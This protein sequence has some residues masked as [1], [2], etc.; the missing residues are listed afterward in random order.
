[1]KNLTIIIGLITCVLFQSFGFYNS[2][3]VVKFLET[4]NSE[5]LE[6]VM[7][8]FEDNSR[9]S[10]HFLPNT[11][12]PREGISLKELN[13][14]QKDLFFK[15]LGYF[16]SETGYNKTKKI[17]SLESVLAELGGDPDYRNPEAY[18]IAIY[19]NPKKD[20]LWAW[21]FEGHHVALNFTVVNGIITAS[22]RFFGANPAIV[23]SGSRK[24]ERTL[25][26][27]EKLAYILVN[28]LT[29]KQREQAIIANVA[30]KDILTYNHSKVKPL[31]PE[32]ILASTLN[33]SQKTQLKAIIFE[34]LSALPDDLAH[35]R[36]AQIHK[37]E[38]NDL[39]FAWAGSTK[40]GEPH[41]YRIQG[42]T[43]LIEL[44]N[45]QT[46]ANHIHCVWR[47]FDGDFGRDLIMEH[48]KKS[49]HHN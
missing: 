20:N 14:E 44:D 39:R 18:F 29:E 42:K 5:Q 13:K 35:I 7:F 4:L 46:N 10:W 11:S 17:I 16:L 47:D 33:N 12:H 21:S 34:Y 24:G 22:P 38:F 9:E 25:H 23:K 43:F 40:K 28:A 45:T 31:K 48:Y 41:Y 27:E 37:E 36:E 2:N 8:P 19:G 15:M 32:G 49:K 1:M 30:Y 3:N 26:R 6:K